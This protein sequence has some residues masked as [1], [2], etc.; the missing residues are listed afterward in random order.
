MAVTAILPDDAGPAEHPFAA[1]AALRGRN[2]VR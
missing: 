2:R 1:L